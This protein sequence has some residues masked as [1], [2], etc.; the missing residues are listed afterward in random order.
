[1]YGLSKVMLL[2]DQHI[3]YGC[4]ENK[5][6]RWKREKWKED[7]EKNNTLITFIGNMVSFVHIDEL[8]KRTGLQIVLYCETRIPAMRIINF[9]D[10]IFHSA[11]DEIKQVNKTAHGVK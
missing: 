8:S 10:F 6:R 4:I 9:D 3:S 7:V 11:I 5:L 1:M 2:S